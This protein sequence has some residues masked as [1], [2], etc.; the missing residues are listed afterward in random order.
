M[1]QWSGK[2]PG[3]RTYVARDGRTA[4][5]L[6]KSV[7]GIRYSIK[8]D[9]DSERAALAELALFER[10]PVAYQ[11]KSRAAV[12]PA[13]PGRILVDADTVGR[14]LA[15]LRAKE[16]SVSYLRRARGYLANWGE[17]LAGRDLRT[18]ELFD[19]RQALAKR[20]RGRTDRMIVFK[21]FCS[22]LRAEDLLK[23][24]EDASLG[25][26]VPKSR[27]EKSLRA[28]GYDMKAVERVYAAVP[29][30]WVRDVV[31]LRVKTGMHHSEVERLAQGKGELRQLDLACGIAGTIRFVHKSG[32]VHIISLDAQAFA[33]AQRLRAEGDAPSDVW[34]RKSIMRAAESI[35]HPSLHPGEFRH[36]FATWAKN[37][38]ELVKPTARGVALE[39]VAAV[40]GHQSAATTSMFYDGT[41]VPPMIALPLRL[42]HP[43]DPPVTAPVAGSSAAA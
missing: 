39:M 26:K 32:R 24:A 35:G 30:Q 43:E 8:L 16:C 21:S 11:T 13:R 25:L 14:F 34:V 5:Q 23:M 38:G 22:W 15:Y 10:D 17:A 6:E 20:P 36:S 18:V 29:S 12:A 2:W 28:K 41:E 3:G 27:P 7:N 1:P 42:V 9:A 40:M 33:A 31:C 4:Y 37:H 19:L